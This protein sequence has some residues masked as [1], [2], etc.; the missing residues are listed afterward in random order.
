MILFQSPLLTVLT[1]G[2]QTVAIYYSA[3]SI[4]CCW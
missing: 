2:S 3:V 4:H 1:I